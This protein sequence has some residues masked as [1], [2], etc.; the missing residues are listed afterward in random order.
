MWYS[1]ALSS[2]SQFYLGPW[3]TFPL[4]FVLVEIVDFALS[5][6]TGGKEGREAVRERRVR[7]TGRDRQVMKG[8]NPGRKKM[9]IGRKTIKSEEKLR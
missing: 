5:L 6:R 1:R 4:G 8:K 9:R 2:I 3:Y 7:Q